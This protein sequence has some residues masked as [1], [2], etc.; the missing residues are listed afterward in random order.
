MTITDRVHKVQ[1]LI[2][3]TANACQR[4]PKDIQ[5][6]AV[7]KGQPASAIQAAF[8]A[9]ISDFGESYLQEAQKKIA[10]LQALPL[11]WHFIGPIQSNKTRSIAEDFSWVH[12]VSR[13]KI[14][15]LLAKYR[16]ENLPTLNL[17]LQVNLDNE[18]NKSGISP[19]QLAKL[20]LVV[21]HLPRLKL[22]GL[23]AIPMPQSEEQQQYKSFLRL[24]NLLNQLNKELNLAMDTLSMGMSD[25]FIAAI[26]AGST[27]VRIG[28]A[29]F[30]SRAS[31]KAP[32]RGTSG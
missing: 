10:T 29:I 9:G 5:L 22:R 32:E 1:Q 8:A 31:E 24:T 15:E 6:L 30:T 7:S 26:K 13:V 18:K 4:S 27:I 12:S 20:A 25:D 3:K 21:S 23:M 19:E 16:P 14:A 2:A 11:C 17:C 28:R